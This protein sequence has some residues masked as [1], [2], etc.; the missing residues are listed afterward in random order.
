MELVILSA[1]TIFYAQLDTCSLNQDCIVQATH[2]FINI[3]EG[4]NPTQ[5]GFK[6]S[7]ISIKYFMQITD[8]PTSRYMAYPESA[9][10]E[11][12]WNISGLTVSCKRLLD[13]ALHMYVSAHSG[14]KN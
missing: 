11:T 7:V 9:I 3:F 12:V 8:K 4:N 1:Q 10:L 5:V 13:S 6:G 2:T 14:F